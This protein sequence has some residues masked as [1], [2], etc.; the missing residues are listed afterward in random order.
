MQ[1]GAT[2]AMAGFD[3]KEGGVDRRDF[4]KSAAGTGYGVLALAGAGGAAVEAAAKGHAGSPSGEAFA[5]LL[6]TLAEVDAGF[7]DPRW[8]LQGPADRAEARRYLAHT[9]QHGL[10]AWLECDP[11]RP[12]FKGFVTP[13]K[14]LLGDNPDAKYH[15]TPVSAQYRYRIRGNVAGATYTSFTV[16]RGTG[17]GNNSRRTGATL[18]DTQFEI[19]PDGSYEIRVSADRQE[20]S[21]LALDPD[22]GSISV[23]HYY[24]R[25]QSIAADRLHHIPIVIERT[26]VTGPEPP[27][28]DESIAAGLRRVAT[29][30]RTTV[31]PPMMDSQ[32]TPRW[33]SLVP[34]ELPAPKKDA[35]NEDVGFA[36]VDNVYSMAPFLLKPGEALVVRGRYP[37]CRFAN[38]VVWNRFMQT[39]DYRDRRV[40]INRKQTVLESDGSFRIVLA[41]ENPGVPNWIDTEGRMLGSMFWRFLLPEEEIEPL[42]TQVVPLAEVR[43]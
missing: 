27:P 38:L 20:G 16:E 22:A 3:R 5:E 39:L 30:V 12:A 9:L 36:A 2:V 14:K 11:A 43:A 10:E 13:E 37:R 25:E 28:T 1:P 40:S 33:V 4:L 35:S 18:N 31:Q 24:E 19:R 42:R 8:R 34:N 6:A 7:D 29:F 41:A 32:K 23:R 21:W 26:D 17:G 15:T